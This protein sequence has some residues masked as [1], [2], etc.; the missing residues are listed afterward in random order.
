MRK[1]KTFL[2]DPVS[3]QIDIGRKMQSNWNFI[4]VG[5][6]KHLPMPMWLDTGV[7]PI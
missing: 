2:K 4:N 7:S 6:S 3:W 1:T 5:S